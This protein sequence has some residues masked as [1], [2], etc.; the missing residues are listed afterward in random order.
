M[1]IPSLAGAARGGQETAIGVDEFVLDVIR[2]LDHKRQKYLP[3]KYLYDAVGSALFEVITL[4]PE[5]GL[6]RADE[7][8]LDIHADKLPGYFPT[9]PVVAELGSGTGTKTRRILDALEGGKDLMYFPIDISV[10]ALERCSI[11][12]GRR[13][14]VQPIADSYV[15]GLKEAVRRAPDERP[16]LLLFL[17]SSIG[18]FDRD[19]GRRFLSDLHGILRPGDV[20][21]LG[22][23]L[24]KPIDQ[25]LAAYDD[26]IGVTAAFDLNVLSRVNR[27]LAADFDLARFRHVARWNPEDR[28]I[29]MHLESLEPQ[30]VRIRRA[31]LTV[32]FERGETIW[33]E[34]SHK[35]TCEE[36]VRIGQEAGFRFADQWT[37]QQW[38]FAESVFVVE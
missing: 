19:V 35:F 18:N 25:L 31:G 20:L 10:A 37:D 15:E 22:T 26:E 36:V 1:T 6:T 33:T 38:P 24:V 23:D 28:R 30:E 12:L 21:F 16:L 7:R 5:Y 2:G 9:T 4:L 3:S 11:D 13:V 27:E 14:E 17:G 8:L 32:V 29:E 34:S